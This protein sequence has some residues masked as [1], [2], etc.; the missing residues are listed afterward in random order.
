[1]NIEDEICQLYACKPA[2]IPLISELPSKP[3]LTQGH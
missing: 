1:M 2:I 3:V